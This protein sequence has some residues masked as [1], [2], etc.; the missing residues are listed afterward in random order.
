MRDGETGRN[1][2]G[3]ESTS[4]ERT[5][6]EDCR[7]VFRALLEA[8]TEVNATGNNGWTALMQAAARE[9]N[10]AVHLL[11]KAGAEVNAT[12][13]LSGET[14]LMMAAEWRRTEASNWDK[15]LED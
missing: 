4:Y 8:G 11:L 13:I 6:Y 2:P 12:G 15:R 9:D 3:M 14:V 10:G 1:V 7:K 5:K